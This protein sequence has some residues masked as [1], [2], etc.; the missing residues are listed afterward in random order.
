MWE[1]ILLYTTAIVTIILAAGILLARSI[2]LARLSDEQIRMIFGKDSVTHVDLSWLG[3]KLSINT[4][5]PSILF[6]AVGAALAV[7]AATRGIEK[8]QWEVTGTFVLPETIE[9]DPPEW[10]QG[11]V[12]VFPAD[13]NSSV[14]P[15]GSFTI[16][17]D[18]PA[19]ETFES[20]F[21]SFTYRTFDQEFN[22][23]VKPAIEWDKFHD[24]R[25]DSL[26]K[27]VNRF[28]RTYD[29]IPVSVVPDKDEGK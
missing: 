14:A 2:M 3:R 23:T 18:I 21:R 5:Y 29:D 4:P 28:S 25:S 8:K 6:L 16:Q 22:I 20:F 11:V 17:A 13:V 26:L 10:N 12:I 1:Q 24:E 19:D 9:Q 15:T 7:I 27:D